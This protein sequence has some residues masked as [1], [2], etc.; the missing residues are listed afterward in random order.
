MQ[1][2]EHVAETLN[3]TDSEVIE[4]YCTSKQYVVA[5][6]TTTVRVR[7]V[8]LLILSIPSVQNRL[9][10]DLISPLEKQIKE[11]LADRQ[12]KKPPAAMPSGRGGTTTGRVVAKKTGGSYK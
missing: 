6:F 2:I 3:S 5:D 10:E 4:W 9:V 12:T 8:L 1:R 7:V 11:Q